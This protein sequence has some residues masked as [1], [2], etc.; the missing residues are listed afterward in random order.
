MSIFLYS[1]FITDKE[2]LLDNSIYWFIISLIAAL[3]PYIKQIKYK[4]LEVLLK[5][6]AEKIRKTVE[7]ESEE[8]KGV[9]LGVIYER[10]NNKQ[11][12][13]FRYFGKGDYPLAQKILNET[14]EILEKIPEKFKTDGYVQNILGFTLK[15]RAM[16]FKAQNKESKSKEDLF[17]AKKI[18]EDIIKH[19][20]KNSSAWLGLGN[21]LSLLGEYEEGLKKIEKSLELDPDNYAALH[22][23]DQLTQYLSKK[24]QS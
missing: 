8:L 23:K 20:S 16:L 11:H 22:D 3:F 6:E 18:F 24:E 5:D 17:K 1:F 10:L 7:E 19:D 9:S 12:D 4:D 14:F 15:N 2:E 21:V 13:F